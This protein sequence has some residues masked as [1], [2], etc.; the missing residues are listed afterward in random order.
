MERKTSIKKG[1]TRG[2]S[3][4][5]L[6]LFDTSCGGS[7]LIDDVKGEV[8]VDVRGLVSGADSQ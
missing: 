3:G 2:C 5:D 4:V 7:K 1:R 8:A 6:R